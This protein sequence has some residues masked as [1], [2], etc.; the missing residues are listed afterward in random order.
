[1]RH[2]APWLWVCLF[3]WAVSLEAQRVV[4][5]MVTD[6]AQEPLPSVSIMVKGV[7]PPL[8]VLSELDGSFRL[9]LPEGLEQAVLVFSLTGFTTLEQA[10]GA[11]NL[12]NVSL[13]EGVQL[14][15]LVVTALGVSKEEKALGYAIS[16]VSG[17]EVAGSGE[18]NAIQGLAAK[19][20]G[21]QVI[22]SGGVPG[23]SSK[24][25]IRGNATFTGE[26]QP[27]MVV[28]GIPYDN[29]TLGSVAGD[30]PF[31]AN[32]SGV[33]N[34]NRALD[35]NPDDIESVTVLKGPAAAAL[36]GTRAANGVLLITTKRGKSAQ[37][38]PG[39][40][41]QFSSSLDVS[42]V[43]RL[44][45][46]QNEFAQGTG[47]GSGIYDA[48]GNLTGINE[49]GNYNTFGR[50]NSLGTAQSWGPRIGGPADTFGLQAHDNYGSYFRTGL[51]TNNNL[52]ISGGNQYSSF[53]L[54]YGN[55]IQ[56]GI[57]PN[58]DLTRNSLRLNA[59]I[60][61][62][63]LSI[64]GTAAY[65]NTRGTKAQNGSNLSG[66][67]LSL[68]RMPAS[69]NILGG[70]GPN[71]YDRPDGEQH[72]YFFAYDNPLWSAFNNPQTDNVNRFTGAVTIDY[73]PLP[74][75]NVTYRL[76]AD[77]YSDFRRQ[78]FAI[79]AFDPPQPTGE[80]WE[81]AKNRLE[82]NS[83]L[84]ITGQHQFNEDFTASLTLGSNLNHRQDK[85]VFTRGRNLAI[86]NFYNLS[87]ASELYASENSFFKRLAGLF[88]TSDL[89][90]K[91]FLYLN[92]AGRHDW[93][94]T[95]GSNL[96]QRGFFYPSASLS[97]A[98]TELMEAND[99]L[100]FGKFR[101]SFAQSGIEPSLYSS[102]T[103]F[104]RPF[105]TDG[106]TDGL[107]FP[108]LG[109]NGFGY[110]PILG[111][112]NL[113]PEIL[114]GIET[115]LDLRFFKGRLNLDLTYYHQRSS[116]L[117]VSRPISAATGF[118]F[119]TTNAG[120]M[121]NQG[122]EAELT[123]KAVKKKGFSYDVSLNFTRN[124]N[125]V[126][127]LA[128]GVDEINLES[129]FAS[130]GSFAIVGQP[131]GAL[132]ATT[133]ERDAQGRLIIGPDGLPIVGDRGNIGNPFPDFLMG[134]RNS[135]SYKGV[136]LSF[137]LDVRK[138]GDIWNGTRARLALLGMIAETADR[139]RSYTIDGVL[140]QTD[141]QGNALF[142]AEGKPLA[143]GQANNIAITPFEYWA[144]YQ[145]DLGATEQAIAD[146]SWIRLREL[147]LSY[148]LP[149]KKLKMDKYLQNASVFF[150][151]RNLALWTNYTNGVDPETSLTGAGSNVNGFD[152]FNMPN[153]KSFIFG[154]RLGF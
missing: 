45:K 86:P 152:Y 125:K 4:T 99:W 7:E 43:N 128:G 49:N 90:Y 150:T 36:Y 76:G 135:F 22:G 61:D 29:Q 57:V 74:W 16:R 64:T 143:A 81:N 92:L 108:Y 123:A 115:G 3:S 131:Y 35:L 82:V 15:N 93:A 117:L 126:V 9:E 124:V 144:F 110:S 73:K 78:I 84:L 60:G 65:T 52:A 56:Q 100:S 83:D 133:W 58:T 32:L 89:A 107:G 85:D 75:L 12:V 103:Y 66:V 97:F 127:E 129:A 54:S 40:R 39:L 134:L 146:G 6:Q 34:S 119:F 26:N 67:M 77:Q 20:A 142:D 55:T 25:L 138:G 87:N 1:M 104:N 2:F 47:G 19:V 147:S 21:V 132:Y 98:F 44:P 151:G 120:V 8:L 27:L 136:N 17:D 102:T 109:L 69:F 149:V 23:A 153:T 24:I 31:N 70:G 79:G 46:L 88:F 112:D 42:Q 71:G 137:L 80:I 41:V 59:Q 30:F 141:D 10:L 96:R 28:D 114:T 94:S 37:N 51:S 106:F 154:L 63:K 38:R 121:V 130:I 48:D 33:N 139:N 116:N 118:R 50:N 72:R 11:D 53:R 91:N 113:K 13:S 140:Q 122:I 105:I 145:S 68:T 101:F 62:E 95:F 148:D 5:G 14:D 111:N 18:V